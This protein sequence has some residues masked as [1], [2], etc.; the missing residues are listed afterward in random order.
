MW[1]SDFS[2]GFLSGGGADIFSIRGQT[3]KG[4]GFVFAAS[5]ESIGGIDKSKK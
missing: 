5:F 2:A 3:N 1:L 4:G